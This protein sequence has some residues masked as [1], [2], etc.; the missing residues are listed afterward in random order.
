MSSI[1]MVHHS[2]RSGRPGLYREDRPVALVV[3]GRVSGTLRPVAADATVTR[4]RG[5]SYVSKE[6]DKEV[7]NQKK[8][9]G[10]GC[11]VFAV[12]VGLHMCTCVVI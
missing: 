2:R 8:G 5:S 10:E 7:R 4:A 1:E 12:C 9:K 11:V 3:R 6:R